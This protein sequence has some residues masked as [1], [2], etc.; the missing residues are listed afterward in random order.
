MQRYLASL[1]LAGT[2]FLAS[3]QQH[4]D[5]VVKDSD[6]MR[7]SASKHTD[8]VDKAVTLSSEQK[9]QV[10]AVYMDVERKLDGMKQRFDQAG[11][12]EEAR[13]EEMRPQWTALDHMVEERLATILNKD[14]LA[15]WQEVNK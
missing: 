10:N 5:T 14:Q 2:T 7:A 15:R 3:A 11:M 6:A 1:L 12:S 8:L 13:Q 9:E 4:H